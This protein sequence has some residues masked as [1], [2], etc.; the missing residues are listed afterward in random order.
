MK[1]ELEYSDVQW[2]NVDE[3]TS[4]DDNPRTIID[5]NSIKELADTIKK[6]GLLQPIAVYYYNG[7]YHLIFGKRRL[8]AVRFNQMNMVPA[9]VLENPITDEI[10]SIIKDIQLIENGQR[11]DVH[12]LEEAYAFSQSQHNTT[13]LAQRIGKSKVYVQNRIN[14]LRLCDE[15]RDYFYKDIVTISHALLLCKLTE[16]YQKLVL[17]N[18]L[19]VT[20]QGEEKKVVG[21]L[22]I[23][24]TIN[25]ISR[26]AT[27]HLKEANFDLNDKTLCK[28]ASS[29]TK[30]PKRSGYN[31]TLFN[32]VEDGDICYDATCF[33][34]KAFNY[35]KTI[36][37]QLSEK[38][39][40][41]VRITALYDTGK[42]ELTEKQLEPDYLFYRNNFELAK[43]DDLIGVYFEHH[44]KNQIGIPFVLYSRTN[45]V[46][47]EIAKNTKERK[48]TNIETI[49][50]EKAKQAASNAVLQMLG[51]RLGA[52][53]CESIPTSILKL[54]A[55]TY[56][57]NLTKEHRENIDSFYEYG[58]NNN[59]NIAFEAIVNKMSTQQL[60]QFVLM[61]ITYEYV[62]NNADTY[63]LKYIKEL[64]TE[65]K[66]D[67]GQ[68]LEKVDKEFSI[69]IDIFK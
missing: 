53:H 52:Y 32:D 48:K 41:V 5:D 55:Y 31:K 26:I 4:E 25:T 33:N 56:Y 64:C 14:L 16:E 47:Q 61:C 46:Q 3:I 10:I 13:E 59:V 28:G 29:C 22:S 39:Y 8:M 42:K 54:I 20:G 43:Q 63:E 58:N 50:Y 21:I 35:A 9:R 66:I 36:E 40:N 18:I 6:V 44:K 51:L 12:P 65:W 23:A 7:Q 60:I 17:K 67:V 27:V 49:K 30:C 34:Q 15:V 38:G 57:N 37:Q 45:D 1:I 2:I 62:K 69:K 68:I 11:K 24:Q 19:K